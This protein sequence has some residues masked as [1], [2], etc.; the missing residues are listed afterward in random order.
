MTQCVA[1][2]D[3]HPQSPTGMTVEQAA[4]IQLQL[5]ADLS[6]RWDTDRLLQVA[7]VVG[8]D[9]PF[10]LLQAVADSPDEALRRGLD[11]LQA[12]EF[13]YEAGLYP[14]LE[15]SF[16]H[17]LTREVAYGTLP[18]ARRARLHAAFAGWLARIGEGRDEWADDPRADIHAV[19]A[20]YVSITPLQT[21][22]THHASVGVLEKWVAAPARPRRR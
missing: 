20:G 15:Y 5:D 16:K 14:D 21:D 9:V 4:R 17:A 10:G 3:A 19:R 11:H 13:L 2:Q 12:A 1:A 18:K 7:S 6:G 8:K 22:T